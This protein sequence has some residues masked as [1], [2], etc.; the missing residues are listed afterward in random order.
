[1]VNASITT[2]VRRIAIGS[3]AALSTSSV[4]ARRGRSDWCRRI[5][6]VAAASVEEMTAA[7][8]N[9]RSNDH[10]TTYRKMQ[11]VAPAVRSTPIVAKVPA[12]AATD[13]S[14]LRW[15]TKPP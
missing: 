12:G 6:N 9:D 14:T 15:V 1:D 10:P 5:E 2:S 7:R 11:N 8:R 3:L 4:E 13:R